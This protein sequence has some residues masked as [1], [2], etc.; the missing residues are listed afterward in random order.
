MMLDDASVARSNAP[1]PISKHVAVRVDLDQIRRNARAVSQRVGVPILAV[2]KAD[3]YGLGAERVARALGDLVGGFC[4]FSLA[5]AVAARIWETT[6]KPTTTLGPDPGV[7]AEDY[8]QHHVRPAVWTV[9][10]AAMLRLARPILSVDTGM[11]RFSCPAEQIDAVLDAGACDEAC[12]H[13]LRASHVQQLISL[14]GGR[15]LRLHAAASALLDEPNAWLDAVRPGI[16]L[17]RGATRVTTSLVD[18]RD[19]NGPAGYTGFSASRHGIILAGYSNG[20]R[21]GPCVINSR[22]SRVLEVGM[23][24]AYVEAAENDRVGDEVVL[25]G[26][27]ISETAL[28]N[29]WNCSPQDALFRMAGTGVRSYAGE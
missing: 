20:L 2:I 8:L 9:E 29:A 10:R 16:A 1:V 24:S 4:V 22:L 3:G 13:A 5:E 23:Q 28:G 15:G 11:Q 19:T 27:G 12:T 7:S 26:D 18:V 14:V 17:Y 25:L 21:P 6:K